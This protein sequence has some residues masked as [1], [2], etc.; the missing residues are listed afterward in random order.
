MFKFFICL[1]SLTFCSLNSITVQA[2]EWNEVKGDHFIVYYK[3]D[4]NF[5][6][7]VE[8]NAEI[9][10]NRI[11]ADLGY[12]RYSNFWQWENRVKIYIHASEDE[13]QKMTGQPGWSH[14]MASYT[15][16]EIHSFH[17]E[18]NFMQTLL[19]HEITHL[20]FRDFVG[21]EGEIPLWLDEGVAE[22]EEPEK[23]AIAKEVMKEFLKEERKFRLHDLTQ[24]DIRNVKI[25]LAVKLFYVQSV[26]VVDFLISKYGADDFIAF[27][28]QLRDEKTLDEALQF[29]YPDTVRNLNE[30][31][32]Q[33]LK[34]ISE[35]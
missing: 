10:Y 16:K 32:E 22:W 14:G 26:S 1:I 15:K 2:A 35:A 9:Y 21:I 33:W 6:K 4:E 29:T 25:E 17:S 12:P 11:A 18:E 23:R 24:I 8:R 20:V 19:P 28:R 5:A 27:C 13:F 3:A 34:Y 7:E 30:L 31:E